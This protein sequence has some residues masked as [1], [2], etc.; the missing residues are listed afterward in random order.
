MTVLF[1]LIVYQDTMHYL[2]GEGFP[3]WIKFMVKSRL[4]NNIKKAGFKSTVMKG[5]GWRENWYWL[6]VPWFS[7]SCKCW[8]LYQ[9]T[10]HYL[11]GEGN[12]CSLVLYS[13][14]TSCGFHLLAI[15]APHH[16]CTSLHFTWH[17]FKT[18]HEMKW[19]DM[20]QYDFTWQNMTWFHFTWHNFT[21]LSPHFTWHHFTLFDVTS[22]H[23]T[24]HDTIWHDL[25]WDDFISLDMPWYD[26]T[27]FHFLSLDMTWLNITSLLLT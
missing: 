23:L 10:V 24:W 8:Y 25:T 19:C 14:R 22:L 7:S 12:W 3:A 20:T 17:H 1:R 21:S 13:F 16:H 26:M 15:T 9:D 5:Y 4:M 6:S 11:W 2:W 27:W 18:W